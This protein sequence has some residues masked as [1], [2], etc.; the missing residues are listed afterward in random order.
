VEKLAN[1]LSREGST[2]LINRGLASRIKGEFDVLHTRVYLLI[3]EGR[4]LRREDGGRYLWG[5][6]FKIVWLGVVG[7]VGEEGERDGGGG[8][9][10]VKAGIGMPWRSLKQRKTSRR[11][12]RTH[13]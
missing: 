5:S 1:Q 8:G 10:G 2:H 6:F 7:V 4:R 3:E 12:R 13:P 11:P 9:A